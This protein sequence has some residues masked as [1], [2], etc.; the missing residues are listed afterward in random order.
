[1]AFRGLF[2]GVDRYQ[3]PAIN[4]L[5]AAG[6]DARALY[7]LFT[8]TFGLGA[9]LLTDEQATRVALEA[10][11]ADLATSAPDDVVVICFSGHGTPS[12]QL[13]TH[14]TNLRDLAS[15][16]IP[17]DTLAQWFSR[18]PARRLVCV[19]DCCFSGGMGAKVLTLDAVPRALESAD[20][21]LE[22]LAG[23]GRLV[24][25]ASSAVEPAYENPRLGHGFLTYYLLEGLQGADP[26]RQRDR[27]S[28]YR[29]LEYVTQQ[30]IA[31]ADAI[32][33]PQHPTTRG[34]ID[35][36]FE[37]PILHRGAAY[38]AAFP[39]S[40]HPP[41]TADINSL[42]PFGLPQ[43]LLD[44]WAAEI[45]SPNELQL[46]AINDC[47]VLDGE[48]VVV[49]APTS[50]GKT[51]VGELG[52]LKG[53]LE[54][55]RAVF[56]LPL[57]ALVNDK[58]TQFRRTYAPF[59]LRIIRATGDT[60]DD[61]PALM[62][63]QYDICLLTY[64][65]YA[66][67]VLSSPHLLR[68]VGTIVVDEVQTIVDPTRGA[69]LEFLLTLIRSRRAAGIEPQIISLSAVIGDTNG[70]DRWLGAKLLR[71]EERPVP[72]CEGV[73]RGDGTFRYLDASGQ[74]HVEPRIQRQFGKGSNR[75]WIIPL[76]RR[77]LD[78]G[79]QVI[80]F[81]DTKSETRFVA[82]Y[83]AETL[84]LPPAQDV[85]DRLPIGDPSAASD[86]LHKV[87]AGGVGFHNSDLDRE[88]RLA[89]EEGFRAP[90]ST[91][92]VLVATT[93]LAMGINTP[94]GAV[95]IVGLEHPGDMP[96]PYS[97]A[98]YKN[99]VGRAGRLGYTDHGESYIITPTPV[100][101]HQAW[102]RYVLGKPEDLVSRFLTADLRSLIL[103]VLTTAEHAGAGMVGPDIVAFLESTFAAFQQRSTN[104]AWS[105]SA[106]HIQ[107]AL[108][109]LVRHG[110]VAMDAEMRF[111]PTPLGRLAAE[112]G[113]HVESIVR[114]SATLR[115]LAPASIMPAALIT[116]TQF[117]VELDEQLFPLN[118]RSTQKEP[119]TWFAALNAQQIPVPLVNALYSHANGAH[120]PTLRAKRAAA[121]LYWM[122]DWPLQK[123]E[124]T[125]TQHGGFDA[126]GAIRNVSARTRDLL[127]TVARVAELLHPGL[128]L[129]SVQR[130]LVVRLELGVPEQAVPLGLRAGGELSRADYLA[131]LRAGL[132][133]LEALRTAEDEAILP[134]IRDDQGKLAAIRRALEASDAHLVTEPIPLPPP[135]T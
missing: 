107:H 13:V 6:R 59:G 55:R 83:L 114:L 95:I 111:M 58:Y 108:D 3:S 69:N 20:E 12:H 124:T 104:A 52:A 26:V 44:A 41:A 100:D 63:G 45:P 31:A 128:D 43:P 131:L 94:A 127:P 109:E 68:Q 86:W 76:V 5:S 8:D 116:A 57:K 129:G 9:E 99:I 15:T 2:V 54:H 16:S 34:Q 53:V 85:L 75:D 51:M 102:S 18:I 79:K 65:M 103:R 122:T 46:A 35:G 1:M 61:V 14:D 89:L 50:S 11:F 101:E 19:L 126:A 47:R 130:R 80:V 48:H 120:V 121:C 60:T 36:S 115:S 21:A 82:Q 87:L 38:E 81:R 133:D 33:Q 22:R 134:H 78:E 123:I 112:S 42:L 37:W 23:H 10:R 135:L 27:V 119:H 98:E 132:I 71:R 110:L 91:L 62:R 113:T 70:L 105:W 30:V 74:E 32:G 64:E 49:T 7:A 117:T 90:D 25:T 72:L 28:V 92:R 24:I 17:L 67:L 118:K 77:L 73:L 84:G 40:V 96:Q 4:W 106:D 125:L 29:L 88:E 56:L 93:T 97:V 66:Q 39:G